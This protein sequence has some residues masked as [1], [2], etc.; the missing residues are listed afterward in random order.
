MSTEELLGSLIGA[1]TALSSLI[2]GMW[3]I[4]DKI[5]KGMDTKIS[6]AIEKAQA[7]YKAYVLVSD[8]KMENI[9]KE[10]KELRDKIDKDL[11]TAKELHNAEMSALSDKIESVGR[12]FREGQKQLMSLLEKLVNGSKN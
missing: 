5:D 7:D 12:D 11:E 6:S 8:I 3:R 2:Y 10:S 9:A 4:K 1:L